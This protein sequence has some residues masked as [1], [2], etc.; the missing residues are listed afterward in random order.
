MWCGR[1]V[2][3]AILVC[4]LFAFSNAETGNKSSTWKAA[5]CGD[6]IIRGVNLGGWLLLE[7]WI[8]P[9]YFEEVNI[10]DLQD[11]IVDEWTYAE[12]LDIDTYLERMINHWSTFVTREDL[13]KLAEAGISHVRVPVGYWYWD[14][15]E[16]EPFPAP[17]MDETDEFSPL[18]YLKRALVWMDELGLQASMDMH[19]GPGSQ[20]GYDNSGKRGEVHWV[21][22]TYP[23]NRYNIDRSVRI[24]DQMTQTMR[25][26]VDSGVIKIETL[27]GIGILNEPHI[28]GYES[29]NKYKDVCLQDFYPKA[30]DAV[31]KYFNAEETNVVMDIA[32]LG[33]GDYVGLF[34][35]P[36]Y[37]G[38]VLDAHSYQCFGG[39]NHWAEEA[40]GWDKHMAESCRL[41]SD[42]SGSPLDVFTGEFSLAVTDCQEYLQGGFVTPYDPVDSSDEACSYYNGDL[43]NYDE[44][45]KEFLQK[46]FLAQLDSFEA[47]ERGVGW[48]MWT[49]KVEGSAGPEWDFLYLWENG[50]IPKDLCSREHICN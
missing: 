40:D 21:D 44:S 5:G 30:Y 43:M 32:S 31:R 28:C 38:V 24:V 27:Y 18:F 46:Y 9:V 41:G 45:H 10:G 22:D 23:E 13:E 19:S 50:I 20:N 4:T 15:D 47:G 11:K 8:T 34:E 33:F 25:E 42:I 35:E 6:D 29:G 17:N 36:T 48:Y 12:F 14:V 37:S 49:M 3:Q 2:G 7:P 1:S 26:W 39:A 16:G